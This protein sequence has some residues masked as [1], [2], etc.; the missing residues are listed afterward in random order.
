MK[1]NLKISIITPSF[2]SGTQIERAIKSVLKQD[3]KNW[4]HIIIDG[5]STDNTINIL[6]KYKHLIWISEKDKG[7]ADAMNKGFKKCT[8]DIIAYLN[9]DDYF[10]PKAFSSVIEEFNK[11]AKF[12]VGNI[13]VISPR[14]KA[15][16]INTPR[17][18]I[19][20]MLRFWEPN[21]FPVNP[22]G[23]FYLKEIQEK[24][25]FN[26]KNDFTMDLEFL[27][28]ASSKYN[29]TKIEKV[30]GCFEDGIN[31]KTGISQSKLNYWQIKNFPY[32]D[33]YLNIFSNEEKREF[34]KDRINGL[35]FMQTQMNN[36]N[37]NSIKL[38]DI[39]KAP[40][41][42]VIIPTYNDSTH[43][44]RAIDSALDQETKNIEII[45]ID[46]C[47]TDNTKKILE[48]KYKNN[49]KIKLFFQKKNN[50]QGY[51]RNFGIKKSKGKY[52]FFI[53]SDDWINKGTL[54]HLLSIAELYK[55]EMV[56]CGINKTYENGTSEFY[57]GYNF[58][59]RGGNEGINYLNEYKIGS[60]VWNKLY[61]K[62]F[63]QK[64]NLKFVT[65]YFHEDV[66]FS[67]EAVFKC[68]KY[69]SIST[70]YYNYF[71]RNSSTIN[72]KQGFIHLRSY[73]MLFKKLSDFSNKNHINN[74]LS[75]H[76]IQSHA[77][78]N[79]IPNIFRYNADNPNKWKTNY[80]KALRIENIK[81]PEA[82]VELISS[83][84]NQNSIINT[85][86]QQ[87]NK[88]FHITD[89]E[90]NIINQ[91]RK[92]KHS[93]IPQGSIRKKIFDKLKINK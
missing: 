3:Y 8:G 9:A 68:K 63:I 34:I 47:S 44:C 50:K 40:L 62:S 37:N 79:A 92:I 84:I 18:T 53:D 93:I 49:E 55:S 41:I 27:I 82:L 4:E 86:P 46:D 90:K 77:I 32:I 91:I 5:K 1:K 33:K 66:I 2:N 31:T 42:S 89:T 11:G 30:L 71:Q 43:V 21:A 70:S 7:Q 38:I 88:D 45:V 13:K 39:R 64:N 20:G 69:I 12:V 52:I 16:F 74:E 85:D 6:K 24:C 29:F 72:S 15:N 61:L 76:L 23:Y 51:Q 87:T 80:L 65:P 10:Y 75:H 59:C 19:K 60:V 54:I 57:H 22:V 25:P 56:A 36:L 78:N 73:I 83:L 67:T 58:G 26:I 35:I 48:K 17:T 28:N 14:L 81:Y